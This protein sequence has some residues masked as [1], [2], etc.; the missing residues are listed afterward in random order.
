[1]DELIT[2]IDG[3]F[4]E[5]AMWN[6]INMHTPDNYDGPRPREMVMGVESKI[7][8]AYSELGEMVYI[9]QKSEKETTKCP[10]C[11]KGFI[12]GHECGFCLGKGEVPADWLKA[13]SDG[14]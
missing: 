5:L 10:Y 9:Q 6:H 3:L 13:E 12:V 7:E 14:E 2:K 1:M 4:Q 8:T 11:Y